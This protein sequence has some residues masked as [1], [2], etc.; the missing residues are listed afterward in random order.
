MDFPDSRGLVF[1]HFGV[2]PYVESGHTPTY[3]HTQEQV[4]MYPQGTGSIAQSSQWQN[5]FFLYFI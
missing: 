4:T 1:H 2:F 5:P 3:P